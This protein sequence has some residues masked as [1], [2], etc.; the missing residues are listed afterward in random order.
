[1]SFVVSRQVHSQSISFSFLKHRILPLA[2]F[3]FYSGNASYAVVQNVL[4]LYERCKELLDTNGN[5]WSDPITDFAQFRP[6]MEP[7]DLKRQSSEDDSM[8]ACVNLAMNQN[9]NDNEEDMLVPLPKM[10]TDENGE[11]STIWLP[12]KRKHIFNINSKSSAFILFRYFVL[13]SQCYAYQGISQSIFNQK[14]KLWLVEEALPCLNDEKLYPG[15]GAVLRILETV[16]APNENGYVGT[17]KKPYGHHRLDGGNQE[18]F[19]YEEELHFDS[20]V[21]DSNWWLRVAIIVSCT[22]VSPLFLIFCVVRMCCKTKRK[23][24]WTDP[25]DSCFQKFKNIL[26]RNTHRADADEFYQYRKVPRQPRNVVFENEK[27]GRKQKSKKFGNKERFDLPLLSKGTDS[28]DDIVLH[29]RKSGK[30]GSSDSSYWKSAMKKQSSETFKISNSSDE[31][32][33]KKKL[34]RPQAVYPFQGQKE[35]TGVDFH[36]LA[37]K[38][39]RSKSP[40]VKRQNEPTKK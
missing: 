15:F 32:R 5:G 12:L 38:L 1:M 18:Q 23:S 26:T 40:P 11:L 35:P 6:K 29:E 30:T 19:S 27:K 34:P 20:G 10:E 28:E 3:S 14:L 36:R 13:V 37:R 39:S 7:L 9:D 16:K 4:N 25:A 21:E 24:A 22:V 31:E 8:K 17:K 33:L 2:K